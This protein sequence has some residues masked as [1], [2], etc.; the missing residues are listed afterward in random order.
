MATIGNI[1]PPQP[2]RS[3]PAVVHSSLARVEPRLT[4]C[5]R[6]PTVTASQHRGRHFVQASQFAV[7][8]RAP[9]RVDSACGSV[10]RYPN[11]VPEQRA[12]GDD[13]AE[14]RR[15]DHW[16]RGVALEGNQAAGEPDQE[17]E[18]G[19]ELIAPVRQVARARRAPPWTATAAQSWCGA[20][21]CITA[22]RQSLALES[23]S[24]SRSTSVALQRLS[25]R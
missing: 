13:T 10:G 21:T 19:F 22:N 4:V 12:A 8:Q 7:A 24:E 18:D 14:Y 1:H 25:N 17:D 3:L 16:Q 15:A 2:I 5:S 6:F 23:S 11:Q 20:L 9:P